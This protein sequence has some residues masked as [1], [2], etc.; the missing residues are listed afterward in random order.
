MGDIWYNKLSPSKKQ[1]ILKKYESEAFSKDEFKSYDALMAKCE[2]DIS[3]SET[4]QRAAMK[5]DLLDDNTGGPAIDQPDEQPI[6]DELDRSTDSDQYGEIPAA[7]A[8]HT[9][10]LKRKTETGQ[11]DILQE[12]IEDPDDKQGGGDTKPGNKDKLEL[13]SD[14]KDKDT[15]NKTLKDTGLPKN[16]TKLDASKRDGLP[17]FM[18]VPAY[19]TPYVATP[20]F[21]G[22]E[23]EILIKALVLEEGFNVNGWRVRPSQFQ[24]VAAQYQQGRQLRINHSKDMQHVIGK[25]MKAAVLKGSE[26]AQYMGSK[27]E[28]INPT[29]MYVA[30]EFV[31]NPADPQVRT[32]ILQGFVETGSIGLNAEAFCAECGKPIKIDDEGKMDRTCRHYDSG[33]DLDSVETKEYSY[34]AEPAYSHSIALPSFGA[35]TQF[36]ASKMVK[37]D[38]SSLSQSETKGVQMSV[39]VQAKAEGGKKADAEGKSDAEGD[40]KFSQ[41]DMEAYAE[42]RMADFKKG[43]AEGAKFRAKSDAE[44]KADADASADAK[45]EAD[46]KAD[47]DAKG[48]ADAHAEASAKTDQATRFPAN[49]NQPFSQDMM[50]KILRPTSTA[51]ASEKWVKELWVAAA[52]HPRAPAEFKAAVK[53][54]YQ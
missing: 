42:M 29:G 54:A 15:L 45:G 48:D 51:L 52:E 34:V 4:A 7:A 21:G 32:N 44:G 35:A 49:R 28:G 27:I 9:P 38:A 11:P 23:G 3:D 12:G 2:A 20:N 14:Q 53:R 37:H 17:Q 25:S 33:V 30:A 13:Q 43:L 47:A 50:A 24:S 5:A 26:V 8:D 10:D 39:S 41:A 31:A 1:E 18:S 22:K 16:V 40:A 46:A 36:M 19:R 6:S